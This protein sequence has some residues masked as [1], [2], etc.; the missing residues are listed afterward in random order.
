[1]RW[2]NPF[3]FLFCCRFVKAVPSHKGE[4]SDTFSSLHLSWHLLSHTLP[5]SPCVSP[6]PSLYLN[7][8]PLTALSFNIAFCFAAPSSSSSLP[9]LSYPHLTLFI[10]PL[11]ASIFHCFSL[12][13]PLPIFLSPAP[14]SLTFN[15]LPLS[16]RLFFPLLSSSRWCTQTSLSQCVSALCFSLSIILS[17]AP[18]TSYTTP[19]P[20]FSSPFLP[21][22]PSA[23][24]PSSAH[25]C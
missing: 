21:F 13:L 25:I 9:S 12:P 19:P 3:L 23:F 6:H 16:L 20:S 18:S 10:F 2:G 24:F 7:V 4:K 5:S 1:M 11:S 8:F 14:L 22:P 17:A 15:A